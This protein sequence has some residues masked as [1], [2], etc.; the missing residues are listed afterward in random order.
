MWE[1]VDQ[2]PEKLQTIWHNQ[3]DS[4]G[5]PL[6]DFNHTLTDLLDPDVSK[7]FNAF[8]AN[9]KALNCGDCELPHNQD[10]LITFYKIYLAGAQKVADA[11]EENSNKIKAI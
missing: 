3:W 11:I 9:Y 10:Q 6:R 5:R 4:T 1:K 8:E 7:N 2:L